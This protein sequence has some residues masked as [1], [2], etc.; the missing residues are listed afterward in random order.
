M[1]HLFS[2]LVFLGLT[3]CYSQS[4]IINSPIVIGSGGDTW[5]QDN[6]NLSFT[7]GELAIST[8]SEGEIIFTQ[9]FHQE[10]YVITQ[11]DDYIKDISVSIFPNPTQDIINIKGDLGNQ[12]ASL[13]IK[14]TKGSVLYSLLDFTGN[15]T[16]QIN[17]NSFAQGVY[18]LEIISESQNKTVFQI[19]KIN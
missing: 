19:Q 11:I 17:L 9:G 6:Y 14:D 3:M 18:F 5:V 12:K 13:Y 15:Q 4:P 7:I 10:N 1:K 2:I 8:F 16:Q